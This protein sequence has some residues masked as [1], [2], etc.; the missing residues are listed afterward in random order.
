M[1]D[2]GSISR[3]LVPIPDVGVMLEPL[4]PELVLASGMLLIL[5]ID[6]VAGKK[7]VRIFSLGLSGL[8]LGI[9][10]VLAILA[11]EADSFRSPDPD[12]LFL[13]EVDQYF[14][15]LLIAATTA[16]VLLLHVA[17]QRDS[18]RG[19]E[20]PLFWLG[21]ALGL[22]LLA[23]ARH[24]VAFYVAFELV[25]LCSYFLVAS[26]RSSPRAAEAALKYVLY[27]AFASALLLIGVALVFMLTGKL[28]FRELSQSLRDQPAESL[29]FA[30]SWIYAGV[31]FKVGALPFQFW[32]PDV[33]QGASSSVATGLSVAPKAVGLM[34][35][36]ELQSVCLP[37]PELAWLGGRLLAI[38]ALALILLAN[39]QAWRQVDFR[40]LLAY[41][42]LAH[43]GYLLLGVA[44]GTPEGLDALKHYLIVYAIMQFGA[45]ALAE[46][47]EQSTGS[48]QISSA[49]GMGKNKPWLGI[50]ATILLVSL[51]G[52]PPFWGFWAK[53][54][55]FAPL[56]IKYNSTSDSFWLIVL[57]FAVLNTVVGLYYYLKLPFFIWLRT[58]TGEVRGHWLLQVMVAVA[59]VVSVLGLSFV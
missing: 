18:E 40:R 13:S 54:F 3:A 32:V 55:L 26:Y 11:I 59:A 52:L 37:E 19:S 29:F 53:F 56:N 34:I 4:V 9:Y 21:L 27:G 47:I 30:W 17:E 49:S 12:L 6:I 14:W 8:I 51:A 42:S 44:V 43:T 20:I 23:M 22:A 10:V 41:S 33:Y 58:G 1:P 57:L 36:A 48:I 2:P 31:A 24:L 45:F 15:R 28:Y 25:S 50:A 5:L 39:V 16:G 38:L 46:C 7:S 35:L